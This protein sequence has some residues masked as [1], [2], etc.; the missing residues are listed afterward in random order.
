MSLSKCY[1]EL[2]AYIAKD[3][4]Y[5]EFWNILFEEY[6]LSKE[7]VLL[8]SGYKNLMEEELVTKSSIEIREKIVIPLL[9]IQQ[10][11][12]QKIEK[13]PV[14]NLYMKRLSDVHFTV[15]LMRAGI[16]PEASNQEQFLA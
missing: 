2:T 3:A 13:D 9:T 6:N 5:K 15:I 4:D 10:Y 8:I 11:A 14:I 16:P 1:F 12:L 7:M